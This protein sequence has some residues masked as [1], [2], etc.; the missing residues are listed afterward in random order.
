M[1]PEC[2]LSQLTVCN[3]SP[4]WDTKV[5]VRSFNA[6]LR[7][8]TKASPKWLRNLLTVHYWSL[9]RVAVLSRYGIHVLAMLYVCMY[10]CAYALVHAFLFMSKR[11]QQPR[12]G[13]STRTPSFPVLY[14]ACIRRQKAY[15]PSSQCMTA[16]RTEMR[17]CLFCPSM[18]TRW[19]QSVTKMATVPV[20]NAWL[21]TVWSPALSRYDTH[22][23]AVVYIYI[24]V[25]HSAWPRTGSLT[26]TSSHK[27]LSLFLYLCISSVASCLEYIHPTAHNDK[28]RTT[29]HIL[30]RC[31]DAARRNPI[32]GSLTPLFLLLSL[33]RIHS[34]CLHIPYTSVMPPF[35]PFPII[36]VSYFIYI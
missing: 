36:I 7:T 14:A 26:A 5:S 22:L 17:R 2:I 21:L 11:V 31:C 4:D 29:S 15:Y 16:H 24:Y 18:P 1:P 12:R 20:H 27:S 6:Y 30:Q 32:V 10:T 35:N 25:C 34:Y 23:F 8:Q 3:R 9:I 13:H 19:H 28:Q 33:N